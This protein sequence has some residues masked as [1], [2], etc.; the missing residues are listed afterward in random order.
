MPQF[1]DDDTPT[2]DQGTTTNKEN[3]TSRHLP[4]RTWIPLLVLTFFYYGW[5]HL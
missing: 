5:N 2:S 3:A 1:Y 4:M